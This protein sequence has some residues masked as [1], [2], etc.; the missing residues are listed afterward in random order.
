M[1]SVGSARFVY[2]I[3]EPIKTIE[4]AAAVVAAEADAVELFPIRF[5]PEWSWH[6]A[7]FP[8]FL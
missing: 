5:V 6:E 1:M 7:P 8:S 3:A 2:L 4:I